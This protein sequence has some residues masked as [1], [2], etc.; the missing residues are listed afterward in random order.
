MIKIEGII[1]SYNEHRGFGFIAVGEERYF[2]HA[3]QLPGNCDR[4]RLEGRGCRFTPAETVKGKAAYNVE[5]TEGE[6]E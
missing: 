1:V 3:T 4:A 6:R 5:F 2:I